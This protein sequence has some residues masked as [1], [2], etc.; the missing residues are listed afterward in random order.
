MSFIVKYRS[1]SAGGRSIVRPRRIEKNELVV[2]R[3]AD[4]DVLLTDLGVT[5]HHAHIHLVDEKHVR[6]ESRSE[7]NLP[8]LING[9][10]RTVA[11]I[12][13][14]R[15]A[16]V[17][18]GPHVLSIEAGTG[19]EHGLVIVNVERESDEEKPDAKRKFSLAGQLPGKR[20]SAWTFSLL[21]LAAFLAWPIWTFYETRAESDRSDRF[22]ADEMWISGPMSDAHANLADDCTACHQQPFVAVR[23]S[24]CL[25]CHVDIPDH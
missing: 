20:I 1:Q 8:L 23:D 25:Q 22:H 14:D 17:R 6:I 5:L 15:G 16:T 12:R 13:V 11:D 19:E 2:G 4:S 21:I 3:G 24:A 18:I 9:K 10:R 7:K